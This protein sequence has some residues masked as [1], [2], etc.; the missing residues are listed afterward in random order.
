M[1]KKKRQRKMDKQ[2]M[3]DWIGLG[4]YGRSSLTMWC[5][6]MG[7]TTIVCADKPY[8]NPDFERCIRMV[9]MGNVTKE[10]L[11]KVKKRFKWYAP[12]IDN[13][14]ELVALYDAKSVERLSLFNRLQELEKESDEIRYWKDEY[15]YFHTR[16]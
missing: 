15:G 7:S 8:D 6:L 2:K 1:L 3:I 13:W 4:Y 9:R 12:Y 11:Q 16:N 10:D 14:D 5:A